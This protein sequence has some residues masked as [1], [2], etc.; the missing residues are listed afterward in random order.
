MFGSSVR[1]R[2]GVAPV[3]RVPEFE[4][5][6]SSDA[7]SA[8]LHAGLDGLGFGVWCV[9][10]T[11]GGCCT[12][13]LHL[14][15]GSGDYV[16]VTDGYGPITHRADADDFASGG[17][18]VGFYMGEQWEEMTN[19]EGVYFSEGMAVGV[20]RETAIV[21]AVRRVF[22]AVGFKSSEDRLNWDGVAAAVL[23][24]VCNVCNGSGVTSWGGVDSDCWGCK[25]IA[26]ASTWAAS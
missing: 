11:G 21:D 4:D 15:N 9:D 20:D 22:D 12:F 6:C 7:S 5:E 19:C 18:V 1:L 3:E 25:C 14:D 10:H 8:L 16:Y 26:E 2:D 17:V 23:A 13:A 24:G